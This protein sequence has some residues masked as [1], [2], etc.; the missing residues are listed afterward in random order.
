MGSSDQPSPWIHAGIPQEI[1]TVVYESGGDA[2]QEMEIH[3]KTSGVKEERVCSNWNTWKGVFFTPPVD[4]F[5]WTAEEYEQIRAALEAHSNVIMT[6]ISV[7][8]GSAG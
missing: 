4:E 7:G 8:D 2:V 6:D 1:V 3:L 5:P